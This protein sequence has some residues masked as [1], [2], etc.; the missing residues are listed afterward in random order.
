MWATQDVL[1]WLRVNDLDDFREIF[2]HNSVTGPALFTS[3]NY[4]Q[5]QVSCTELCDIMLFYAFFYVCCRKK[6][7]A[8]T[9]VHTSMLL[10]LW[11][12]QDLKFPIEKVEHLR[13]SVEQLK[14]RPD[15]I[16]SRHPHHFFEFTCSTAPVPMSGDTAYGVL[17]TGAPGTCHMRGLDIIEAK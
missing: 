13:R 14:K 6:N 2:Y 5:L 1:N 17:T 8:M 3:V 15:G 16:Q 11:L 9:C 7:D 4:K 12:V 10:S